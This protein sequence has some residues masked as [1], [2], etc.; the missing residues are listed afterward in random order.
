MTKVFLL[1]TK[2]G[3]QSQ[4]VLSEIKEAS[5]VSPLLLVFPKGSSVDNPPPEP[6]P[7]AA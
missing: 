2:S 4:R 5:K 3:K 7:M 1:P 6:P